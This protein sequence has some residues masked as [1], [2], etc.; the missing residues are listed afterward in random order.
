MLIFQN[1]HNR[2]QL[3]LEL[4][5]VIG[6]VSVALVALTNAVI[7]AI[8]SSDYAKS[9][10][11]ATKLSTTAIE[12]TKA[13]KDA[14]GWQEFKQKGEGEYCLNNLPSSWSE[15][16]SGTECDY[17]IDDRY[18]RVLTISEGCGDSDGFKEGELVE[19]EV[20]VLVGWENGE[21]QVLAS[22]CFTK[23]ATIGEALPTPVGATVTPTPLPT[24]TPTPTPLPT[25]TP[26]PT[27]TID[28][29][30]TNTPT[31]TPTPTP[32]C[33]SAGGDCNANDC[34][35]GLECI[36]GTCISAL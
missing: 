35:E 28:P 7:K 19:I 12:W 34:C 5:V 30:I 33:V 1:K 15:I 20:S 4:V 11:K 10:T 6:L 31:P 17:E 32:D 29:N 16:N 8:Q 22:N 27:P 21:R 13:Q 23:R 24:G 3:L 26:T 14:V 9:K 25:N 2:G 36:A 18:N